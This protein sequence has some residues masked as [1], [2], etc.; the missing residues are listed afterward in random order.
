MAKAAELAYVTVRDRIIKGAYAGG[1]RITEQEIADSTGVSRTPVREALRRLQAEG[2]VKVTANHGAIVTEWSAQD[3]NYVF[4]LRALLEPYGAARAAK[5]I[6][7]EGIEELRAL[8]EAQHRE[9]QSRS[10]GYV[11]RIRELNSA[12]HRVLQGYSGN[13][14]LAAMLPALMEAP[15]VLKTLANYRPQDLMRS[16]SHHL[17]IVSALEARDP[18]WAA[19][20][21]RCHIQAAHS[22]SRAFAE[23]RGAPEIAAS[24]SARKG[25]AVIAK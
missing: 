20:I 24:R 9:S 19:A 15:L 4:E 10:A 13:T 3:T 21:M 1:S 7:P 6:T 22:T 17:E 5:H 16:A 2:F 8:A 14:R 11:P 18:E 12:F 25:R 23:S